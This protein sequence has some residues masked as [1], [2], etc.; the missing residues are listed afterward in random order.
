M[1][2][3]FSIV[4]MSL[5]FI[6]IVN[7]RRQ[8]EV[9]RIVI[10]NPNVEIDFESDYNQSLKVY[11]DV[12]KEVLLISNLDRVLEVKKRGGYGLYGKSDFIYIKP[13]NTDQLRG[14]VATLSEYALVEHISLY[15]MLV[16]HKEAK[17]NS[18]K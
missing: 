2:K 15:E 13:I 8:I 14:A 12:D 1:I 11:Y 10:S 3:F 7:Q 6:A 9:K 16:M 5:T 4:L 17:I 18:E